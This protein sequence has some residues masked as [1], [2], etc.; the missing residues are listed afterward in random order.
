VKI[1]GVQ[2]PLIK[3]GN[4]LVE[5]ILDSIEKNGGIELKNNDILVIASSAV[6]TA[7]GRTRDIES[8]TPR[9]EAE[10][11]ARKSGLDERLVEIVIQE[12]DKILDYF[13]D[14]ILTLRDGMLRINA[15]V[16]RSN[17]P[18]GK[19]LLLPENPEDKAAKIR[20]KLEKYTE[21]R[22]GLVISDSHVNP[23]R[24]GTVGQ[25]IGTSGIK[26]SL[27]RRTQ[28]D[29]YG[30]ELKITFQGIGDQLAT[31]AQL[32]MGEADESVPIA[33]IRGT[34]AA[35][36]DRPGRSLKISPKE[37]VYSKLMGLRKND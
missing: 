32:V 28:K 3:P 18:K 36:S 24:R 13:E 23:L 1:I 22:L 25:A 17:V 11:L 27:D 21:K 6:S 9:K 8:V 37:C 20:K 7:E 35:F 19:A 26:E 12:S 34:E 10:E 15:G 2:T 30:R 31:A 4:D 16:D 33:V 5:I 14:C 29:L